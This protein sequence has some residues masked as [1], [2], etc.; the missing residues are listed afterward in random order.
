[1]CERTFQ[2]D[3]V[4]KKLKNKEKKIAVVGLGYVGFPL[5]VAFSEKYLVTGYDSNPEKIKNY[6]MGNDPTGEIGVSRL[7]ECQ[8]QFTWDPQTLKDA[9]LIIVAVPTPVK[10][11]KTPDLS[12]VVGAS[13]LIGRYF[14]RG[15]VVVF[16]STVYPGVTER[17]CAPAIEEESGLKCGKDFFIGYSPERVS[18]GDRVHT[19]ESITKIVSASQPEVLDF[20]DIVYSSIL[21]E[22][23]EPGKSK[24]YRAPSIMVAEAAKLLENSQRDVNIAF[25]NEIAMGLHCMGIDTGEV[26][27]AMNTK[28]NALHFSPGLVGGHCIG[29][30]PYYF[31]YEME[32]LGKHSPLIES[33]RRVN[34]ELPVRIVQE[35]VKEITK[36]GKN[37]LESRIYIL[38]MTFKG[39][40]PDLRNT[41]SKVLKEELESY[42]LC[43]KI[44]DPFAD[45]QEMREMFGCDAVLLEE[46]K[47]ADCLIFAA[48][49]DSYRKLTPQMLREMFRDEGS[50]LVVDIRSLFSRNDVESAGCRYWNL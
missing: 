44:S 14:S 8:V 46:I 2:T 17:I 11:D 38:G 30:D 50:R 41:K 3:E 37:L 43:V 31:L 12:C 24:T 40:C 34:D 16:E 49:H 19:L 42:G 35:T 27:R 9:A 7:K 48:D 22:P 47:E 18:P 39:N 45:P 4:I 1:M 29:V 32:A 23:A 25:M 10:E 36:S 33:A 13:R 28:W 26:F 20:L 21:K 6:Q 15:T 5:A